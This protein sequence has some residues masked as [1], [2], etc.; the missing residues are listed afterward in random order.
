M[1]LGDLVARFDDD[2]VAMEALLAIGDLS[3]LARVEEAA[4]REGVTPGEF[5]VSAG[6]R[7]CDGASD[8]DWVSLIGVMGRTD[9]PGTVCLKKMLEFALRPAKADHSCSHHHA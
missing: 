6:H 2:A 8:D 7:F 4:A 5:A 9:D 1:L 3:L